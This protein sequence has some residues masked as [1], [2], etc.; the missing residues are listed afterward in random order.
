MEKPGRG[1][2]IEKKRDGEEERSTKGK[3][4]VDTDL[5]KKCRDGK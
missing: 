2:E 3:R 4:E 5:E 1:A